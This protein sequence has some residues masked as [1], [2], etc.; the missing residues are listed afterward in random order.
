MLDEELE[1]N[2]ETRQS[3]STDT[4]GVDAYPFTLG[5]NG[6]D[7]DRFSLCQSRNSDEVLVAYNVSEAD[8]ESQ[9]F[10]TT[11]CTPVLVHIIPESE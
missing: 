11:T 8:S 1:S 5:V 10:D 6:G 9:D 7:K 2:F 3:E 4:Y